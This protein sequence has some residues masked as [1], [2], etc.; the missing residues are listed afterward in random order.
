METKRPHLGPNDI[1][2]GIDLATTGH[3]VAVISSSGTRLNRFKAAHSV[4]GL[5]EL[6]PGPECARGPAC[7]AVDRQSRRDSRSSTLSKA[8]GRYN[9]SRLS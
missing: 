7:A 5:N 8:M 1:A 4:H 2:V 3:V 6:R 9:W